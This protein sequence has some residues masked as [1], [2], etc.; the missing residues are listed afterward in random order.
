[1]K[2]TDHIEN[3]VVDCNYLADP[4]DLLV[5]S[6]ACR[7]GKEIVISGHGTR[8]IVKGPWLSSLR[9]QLY[10]SSEEWVPYVK[11]HVM[12]ALHGGHTQMPAYGIG[13]K[14]ADLIKKTWRKAGNVDSR[15]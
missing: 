14:C 5:L 8:D 6:E 13:E 12:P 3:P 4:L 10:T 15:M 1:M 9:H 7:F 2:S 11:K